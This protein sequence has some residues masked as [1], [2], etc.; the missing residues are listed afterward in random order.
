ML[1]FFIVLKDGVDLSSWAIVLLVYFITYQYAFR[2]ADVY[3]YLNVLIQTKHFCCKDNTPRHYPCD[4][5]I[6]CS[7]RHCSAP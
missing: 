5:V 3:L 6:Y 2:P 4:F 1:L 7:V